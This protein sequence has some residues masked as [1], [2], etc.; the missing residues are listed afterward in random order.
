MPPCL[1]CRGKRGNTAVWYC[2]ACKKYMPAPNGNRCPGCFA[3]ST[4]MQQIPV[5]PDLVAMLLNRDE[6]TGKKL[7]EAVG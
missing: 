3:F 7:L 6:E 1:N 5:G 2:R 4:A